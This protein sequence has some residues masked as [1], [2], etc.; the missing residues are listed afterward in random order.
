M[1]K[2]PVELHPA[3]Q[4][5]VPSAITTCSMEGEPN[6]TYISQVYYVDPDHL[7]LSYQFFTKTIRNIEQNPHVAVMVIHPT[8]LVSY[9]LDLRFD[10]RETEGE[11]FEQM[12]MQLAAI[13]SMS[14]M[15]NVFKLKA[16]DIYEVKT[17]TKLDSWE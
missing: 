10:H 8:T 11:I 3:L 5:V 4:G 17:V 13:A 14:G 2:I 16:A 6:A 9:H 15:E 12:E 1:G 7:A